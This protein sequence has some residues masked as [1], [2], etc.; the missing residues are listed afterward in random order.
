MAATALV[1]IDIGASGVRGVEV[2]RDKRSGRYALRRAASI[3]LPRGTV[4]NGVVVESDTVV[5]ALRQLWRKGRFSTRRVVFGVADGNVLTRQLDLPWMPPSDFRAALRYQVTD[6]LPVELATV[7]L[8]YHLL[9]EQQRTDEHGQPVDVNRI[10]IAATST[11]IVLAEAEVVQ[12][13]RLQ[14]VVADTIAFALIRAACRGQV[15]DDQAVHAIADL[16]ADQ[17]TVAIHTGGQPRFIRTISNLGGDAATIG[18]AE[19]LRVPAEQA[20]SIKRECGLNGPAPVVAAIAE[21]SV[22]AEA[23]TPNSST[24]N[25]RSAATV[26]TLGAWATR[27]IGE[28]RNSLDYFQ[29]SEPSTL[30]A[31][32]TVTGRAT[33]LDGMVERIATQLPLPVRVMDPLLGLA[34]SRK[35]ARQVVSDSRLVVAAG[36]AMGG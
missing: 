6:A 8:D 4:R 19:R 16:G 7:Q 36:L 13:A 3:D 27:V 28:I 26:E 29:A 34:P 18:V 35:V 15:P 24:L 10:L 2:S 33:L 17:L 30:I 32:L 11:D 25:P 1:G 21:S 23:A 12:R 22:F 31:D 5:V 20:E 9:D 14:P